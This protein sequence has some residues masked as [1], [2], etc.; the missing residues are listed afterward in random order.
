MSSKLELW[1]NPANIDFMARRHYRDDLEFHNYPHAEESANIMEILAEIAIARGASIELHAVKSSMAYHDAGTHLWPG[2]DHPFLTREEYA[3]DIGSRELG[4]LGMPESLIEISAGVIKS[5]NHLVACETGTER[6]A[7]QADLMAGGILSAPDVFL[8]G[9]YRLYRESKRLKD[10][11]P[12]EPSDRERLIAELVEFGG[13]SHEILLTFLEK[14]L[15]LGRH[16]KDTEGRSFN[17]RAGERVALL[18]P[19]RIEESFTVNFDDI[20]ALQAT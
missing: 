1:R 15:S 18:A 13:V 2:V 12:V 4:M 20:L 11:R 7:N 9:T 5:T 17:A 8:H 16:D 3:A 14:D 6:C 10:E 19:N